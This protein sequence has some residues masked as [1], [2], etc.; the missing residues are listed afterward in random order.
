MIDL[1]KLALWEGWTLVIDDDAPNRPDALGTPQR[2]ELCA[3]ACANNVV[4]IRPELALDH[5]FYAVSHEIGEARNG[6]RG[7]TQQ[8]WREQCQ[9][10]SRWCRILRED[11]ESAERE[12]IA[13]T[14]HLDETRRRNLQAAE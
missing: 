14:A 9:I 13:V 8:V 12:L 10:M 1:Y 3:Q 2:D 11:N 7:H 4:A 5:A 6:F